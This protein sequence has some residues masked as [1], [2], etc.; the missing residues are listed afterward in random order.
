MGAKE[1][2]GANGEGGSSHRKDRIGLA[3]AALPGVVALGA[4]LFTAVQTQITRGQLGATQQQLKITEQGQ[5]TDRYTA[6][7]ANLGTSSADIRLGGIYALQRVMH[8]S[9]RDQPTIVSVLCAFARNQSRSDPKRRESSR[10]SLPADVQAALTVVGTRKTAHDGRTTVIDFHHAQLSNAQLG[11]LSLAH[12]NL[13][14]ADLGGAGLNYTRLHA[15][16]LAGTD[17]AG[18]SLVYAGLR[19]ADLTGADLTKARLSNTNLTRANLSHVNLSGAVLADAKLTDASFFGANLT[20]AVLAGEQIPGLSFATATLSGGNLRYANLKGADLFG[21]RLYGADLTGANL[22][23]ANLYAAKTGGANFA[24]AKL[25]SAFW[26]PGVTPPPG[27]TRKHH[28]NRLQR[29]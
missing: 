23:G 22:T 15:A 28:S 4:L 10:V 17:L 9:R 26:P 3:V 19:D 24:G 21:A 5:I 1:G 16:N 8:D 20:G 25:T 2:P 27:W 29:A 7:I 11:Y 13:A 12:A 14:G 6:A 18:A